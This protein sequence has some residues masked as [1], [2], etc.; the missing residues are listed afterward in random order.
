MLLANM[1]IAEI[2]ANRFPEVA[3]LRRHPPPDHKQLK[4]VVRRR[5][6]E[7]GF[8]KHSLDKT[9]RDA[10]LSTRWPNFSCAT[11]NARPLQYGSREE[12]HRLSHSQSAAHEAHAIG[13]LLLH[14]NGT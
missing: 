11:E 1:R 6:L 13:C 12:R 7:Q 2:I 9:M 5:L 3:L 10:R 8:E 4:E 14:R